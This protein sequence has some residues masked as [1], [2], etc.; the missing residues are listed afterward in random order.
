MADTFHTDWSVIG[1]AHLGSALSFYVIGGLF[2]WLSTALWREHPINRVLKLGP[3]VTERGLRALLSA[4]PFL[5]LFG[6][7][8]TAC[9]VDHS[10]DFLVHLDVVS[11]TWLRT[12]AVTE[13]VI[14]V[15][16]A[17]FLVA[18]LIKNRRQ[19]GE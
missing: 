13:A 3:F 7:F 16:T 1:L 11:T 6:A 5:F 4:W 19:A 8:V 10:F 14:S 17:F 18:Y 15:G 2:L 12:S 9:A